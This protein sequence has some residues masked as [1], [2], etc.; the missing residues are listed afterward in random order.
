VPNLGPIL[1][2]LP[3]A[4]LGLAMGPMTAVWT[5]LVYVI[6]Q[7]LESNLITPLIE[8]RVVSMPPALLLSFQ[9]LMGMSGGVIGLVI[10]TPLLV[11]I[12]VIVQVLYIRGVLGDDDLVV[13]GEHPPKPRARWPLRR[14]R[15]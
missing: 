15:A 1:S 9:L 12:V 11:T 3:A 13:I 14:G 4:L 2:V 8:Q 7:L 10:A 6:V 5:V